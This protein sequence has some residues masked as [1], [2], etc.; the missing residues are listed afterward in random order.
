[1]NPACRPLCTMREALADPAIFGEILPGETWAPWRAILTASRGEVLTAGER[2]IFTDLTRRER[3][4]ERPVAA[5]WGSVGSRGGKSPAFRVLGL[6]LAG[7]VV[8]WTGVGAS[9]AGAASSPAPSA[10]W[11]PTSP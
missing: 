5:L 9:G 2:A 4:P 10:S 6:C 11:A 3:E 1:M 7:L 8:P